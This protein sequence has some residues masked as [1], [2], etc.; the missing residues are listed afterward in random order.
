MAL[1]ADEPEEALHGLIRSLLEEGFSRRDLLHALE[2]FRLQHE[3]PGLWP[4]ADELVLD[5][6]AVLDGWASST[7]VRN[8]M[9][10]PCK[11]PRATSLK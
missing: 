6:M 7:A 5:M 10:P 9:P 4:D 2:A 11:A 8:L 3:L 1:R